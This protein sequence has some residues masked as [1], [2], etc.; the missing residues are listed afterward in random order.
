MKDSQ[1][2]TKEK[3]HK[4]G[5]FGMKTESDAKTKLPIRSSVKNYMMTWR[6]LFSTCALKRSYCQKKLRV[7][8]FYYINIQY[9]ELTKK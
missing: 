8:H 2:R 5:G 1:I 9:M 3:K 7:T 4:N 6:V